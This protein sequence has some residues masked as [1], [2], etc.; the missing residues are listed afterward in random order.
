MTEAAAAQTLAEPATVFF[1]EAIP[2][3]F[4][5][6]PA[7]IRFIN[8]GRHPREAVKGCRW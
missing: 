1:L 5:G 7:N 8:L 4:F 3:F 6:Y 2:R